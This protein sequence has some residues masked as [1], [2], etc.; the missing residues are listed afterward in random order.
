MVEEVLRIKYLREGNNLT[1]ICMRARNKKAEHIYE[2]S[3]LSIRLELIS[4][5]V[6]FTV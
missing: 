2:P 5:S 4:V 1:L 6:A 3:G